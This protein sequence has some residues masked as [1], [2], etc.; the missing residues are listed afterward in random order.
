MQTDALMRFFQ[1]GMIVEVKPAFCAGEPTRMDQQHPTYH[2][3]QFGH[4]TL[5][6]NTVGMN[7][8]PGSL[9]SASMQFLF[10]G[11]IFHS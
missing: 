8:N 6:S 5:F 11:R 3:R 7:S 4:K 1:C 10:A 2:Y 9:A